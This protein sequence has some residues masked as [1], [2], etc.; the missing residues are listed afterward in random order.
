MTCLRIA[1]GPCGRR[2]GKRGTDGKSA[3]SNAI[4]TKGEWHCPWHFPGYLC[5]DFSG[6]PLQ[7]P[8]PMPSLLQES[9]R[10]HRNRSTLRHPELKDVQRSCS[11]LV[12]SSRKMKRL[13]DLDWSGTAIFV[14]LCRGLGLGTNNNQQS[15]ENCGTSQTIP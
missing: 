2:V 4:A 15:L 13:G 5:L 12:F 1:A 14:V 11:C 10:N 7:H 3:E 8:L 9:T 6:I